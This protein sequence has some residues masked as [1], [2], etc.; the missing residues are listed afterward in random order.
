MKRSLMMLGVMLAATLASTVHAEEP[1]AWEP[2]LFEESRSTSTLMYTSGAS[3]GSSFEGHCDVRLEEL[4]CTGPAAKEDCQPLDSTRPRRA[5]ASRGLRRPHPWSRPS[6]DA[7]LSSTARCSAFPYSRPLRGL[8]L[9]IGRPTRRPRRARHHH[10]RSCCAGTVP[11]CARSL[12]RDPREG[13]PRA[14]R[15]SAPSSS[16]SADRDRAWPRPA[17]A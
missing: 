17:R 1:E 15:F 6:H 10:A 7:I 2:S 14:R 11:G 8:R 4:C 3:P 5:L 12:S 9:T 13:R 16:V